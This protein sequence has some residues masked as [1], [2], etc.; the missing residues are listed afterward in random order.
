MDRHLESLGPPVRHHR[1]DVVEVLVVGG[2]RHVEAFGMPLVSGLT[3]SRPQ[4]ATVDHT[5]SGKVEYPFIAP[6]EIE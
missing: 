2:R 5:Y 6:T 4:L 3:R 1:E